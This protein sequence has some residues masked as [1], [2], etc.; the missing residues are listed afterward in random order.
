MLQKQEQLASIRRRN[1]QAHVA[2]M[3]AGANGSGADSN[4]NNTPAKV[5]NSSF[6]T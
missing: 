2:S 3:Q 5:T 4:P 6:P 1:A